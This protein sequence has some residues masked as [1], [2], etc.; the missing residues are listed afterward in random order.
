MH[1]MLLD[2]T[3]LFRAGLGAGG[4]QIRAG[5]SLASV[6]LATR[7]EVWRDPPRLYLGSFGRVLVQVGH[8]GMLTAWGEKCVAGGTSGLPENPFISAD[9]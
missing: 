5:S 3:L 8:P 9:K 7:V 6:F 1:N 2:S 4:I